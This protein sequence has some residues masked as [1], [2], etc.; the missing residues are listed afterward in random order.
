MPLLA[1]VLL[2]DLKLDHLVGLLE[3]AEDRRRRLAHLKVDRAV[4]DLQDRGVVEAAVERVQVVVGGARAI[5]LEVAPVHVV[6]VDET[7]VEDQAAVRGQRARDHVGGVGVVAAVRRGAEASLRV[8]L[9]HEAAEVRDCAV[10]PV[11]GLLPEGDDARVERIERGQA[12]DALRAAEVDRDEEAHAPGA[13]R[14]GDARELG[15]ELGREHARVGVDVV[16]RAGVDADRRH[17][18]RVVAHA[19]E[20]GGDGV[21]LEEDRGAGVAALDGAVQV[22]PVIEHAHGRV[23]ELL[24]V[25][26]GDR[27]A[28][29]DLAR[30][31]ERAVEH[32]AFVGAGDD[33]ARR[34]GGDR[35]NEVRVIREIG[36]RA[37]RRR[38]RG[39]SGL[40]RTQRAEHDRRLA[41]RRRV[42]AQ[43]AAER[44]AHGAD[45]L[46]ARRRQHD[47]VADRDHD[48]RKRV[49]ARVGGRIGDRRVPE[50]G[51]VAR[52]GASGE[53][54]GE[55]GDHGR[56]RDQGSQTP[57]PRPRGT[58]HG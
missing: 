18:A 37:Q 19:R 39:L 3:A 11:D 25:E 23:G 47:G 4:L 54:R 58:G 26:R 41:R 28:E 35:L 52:L 36:G 13:E 7:A 14:V 43:R 12:A 5:V 34:A 1:G 6:V 49:V 44:A 45:D 57:L 53:R 38:D 27:L 16:D 56:R 15:Q 31:R 10:D 40:E 33:Q 29:V 51:V 8:G 48:R 42:H 24:L 20:V 30:Q 22:V 21:V 55:R 9:E 17:Q 32:T 2:R 46:V 50:P